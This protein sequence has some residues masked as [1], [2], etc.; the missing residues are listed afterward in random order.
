MAPSSSHM[1]CSTHGTAPPRPPSPPSLP[2]KPALH[3]EGVQLHSMS[4]GRPEHSNNVMTIPPPCFMCQSLPSVVLMAV[5]HPSY[6]SVLFSPGRRTWVRGWLSVVTGVAGLPVLL[7]TSLFFLV[8]HHTTW[9]LFM[10]ES[11]KKEMAN[12]QKRK[13]KEPRSKRRV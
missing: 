4:H 5:Y 8:F 1:T 10:W 3:L 12:K 6:L 13:A 11:S 7:K 9:N 2:A